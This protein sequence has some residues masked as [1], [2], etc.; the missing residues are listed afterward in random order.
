MQFKNYNRQDGLESNWVTS[1]SMCTSG[2]LW[3]GTSK[4]IN[5]I[6]GDTFHTL[7]VNNG[8]ISNSINTI[9]HW[10][11]SI[12]WIGTNKGLS[13]VSSDTVKNF[14]KEHYPQLPDNSIISIFPLTK[15]S[16]YIGTSNGIA[17]LVN[18][19]IYFPDHLQKIKATIKCFARSTIDN[20]IWV[21]TSKGLILLKGQKV[22]RYS[23]FDGLPSNNILTL[24]PDRNGKM[25]IGTDNGLVEY[26]DNHFEM[27]FVDELP[28]G[29]YIENI[30]EDRESN[31]WLG[32]Y[33]GLYKFNSETFRHYSFKDGL[34]ANFIYGIMRDSEEQLWVGTQKQGVFRY[35]GDYF[36]AYNSTH[37]LVGN[38]I[39]PIK[40]LGNHI[41]I[42]TKSGLS[43]YDLTTKRIIETDRTKF[44]KGKKI[45]SILVESPDRVL[46]GSNGFIYEYDGKRFKTHN[47]RLE[48]SGD[49]WAMLRDSIGNLWVGTYESGL[50]QLL[51]N[52]SVI[53]L[54]NTLGLDIE[55]ALDI[56]TSSPHD[57]WIGT[58]QG[59]FH[60]NT[61]TNH[62][63]HIGTEDGIPSPFIYLLLLDH[64][65]NLW[66]GSNQGVSRMDLSTY[67]RFGDINITSFGKNDG[68][69][70]VECNAQAAWADT[71]NQ[72][73]FGTVNGLIQYVG[74]NSDK[75]DVLNKTYITGTRIFYNDTILKQG[76]VL[77]YRQN[78]ISFTF[79]GIC[80]SNPKKVRYSYMLEGYDENWSPPTTDRVAAYSNLKPGFYTF[81]VKSSNVNGHWNRNPT[82][83]S[84]TILAPVYTQTWF[85]V[86]SSGILLLILFL[87]YWVRLKQI[88]RKAQLERKLDNLELQ[89]LRSQMNPH[90][91]FNSMNS[92]QHY[93]NG[94]EQKQANIYLTKFAR[95]MR[96]ILEN[97]K[98]PGVSLEKDLEAL[99]IYI[100]LEQM[101]F[102]NRFDY[103]I[104][105]ANSIQP[106]SIHIPSM[107]LQPFV[108][109]SINHGFSKLNRIGHI[110]I[111]IQQKDDYLICTITDNG[112][113]RVAAD[114]IR[115]KKNRL[116]QSA[117]LS[118]TQSRI[119]T[120]KQKYGQ[121]LSI[122]TTDLYKKEK[123]LGTKVVI[124]IPIL[125]LQKE[126][127]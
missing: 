117:G 109:N 22:K 103:T 55:T 10:G 52:D 118:I 36:T 115:Q 14:D 90:F 100:K 41:L 43:E 1:I 65:N 32:T 47:L 79:K 86:L 81:K 28:N 80:L 96:L 104:D 7:S 16:V 8:L 63:N 71:N 73:W 124:T 82:T 85:I 126:T 66:I 84:F 25:W 39:G 20:S 69:V 120:M 60:I 56:K 26:Q 13:V 3:I 106:N 53:N 112:I 45:N 30:Y 27:L 119:Q 125:N 62:V 46:F 64:K 17:L 83:L 91:I 19:K 37:G 44:L 88:Q 123:P 76:S 101:R 48:K 98:V 50:L 122:Q 89:A 68:F 54:G 116:H 75:P 72:L 11:D 113:G 23:V 15:D 18:N 42:G 70:G 99:E 21:G 58:F 24:C 77:A 111:S 29:N 74:E 6:S 67:S 105:I 87:I 12:S 49:V 127:T 95:L 61:R 4:G 121:E 107:L 97:S 102:E 2:K 110:Q 57:F 34:P 40:Q 35:N 78:Q 9:A 31:I 33:N 38:K 108:E 92:I 94:N 51:P 93:I 5:I 59:V 114:K